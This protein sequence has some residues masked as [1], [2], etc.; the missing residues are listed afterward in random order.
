MPDIRARILQISDLHFGA[1]VDVKVETQV[2]NIVAEVQPDILIAS[3]DL[4]DSPKRKLREEAAKFL[5]SLLKTIT[6]P[7]ELIVIPGNH[8]YK[9]LFGSVEVGTKARRRFDAQFLNQALWTNGLFYRERPDLGVLIAGFN[10]NPPRF[11]WNA[12]GKVDGLA[13]QELENRFPDAAAFG[14][15]SPL[16]RIA[17]V[18]HH[19][20]PIVFVSTEREARLEERHMVFYNA[21]TF[22][23]TLNRKGFHLVLHG[24]KHFASFQRVGHEFADRGRRELA[25]AGAGSALHPHPDDPNGNHLQVVHLYDDGTAELDSWFYSAEVRR[26][27]G[28]SQHYPI[29][30]LAEVAHRRRRSF[31]LQRKLSAGELRREIRIT[32]DGFSEIDLQL[33][34]CR[35]PEGCERSG[36]LFSLEVFKPAY[37]RRVELAHIDSAPPLARLDPT[38][39]NLRAYRGNIDFQRTYTAQDPGFNLACRYRLMNGHALSKFDFQRKY[40]DQTYE[41]VTLPCFEVAG[42][43][44][45]IVYFPQNY[46]LQALGL[47]AAVLYKPG[48]MK[49]LDD[50]KFDELKLHAGETERVRERLFREA[51]RIVLQCS[52]PVPGFVYQVRWTFPDVNATPAA[53]WDAVNYWSDKKRALLEIAAG[54]ARQEFSAAGVYNRLRQILRELESGIRRNLNAGP[55]EM[56]LTLLAFDEREKALRVVASNLGKIEDLSRISLGTGE[57]CAGFAFEK[58]RPLFY[59]PTLAD[60]EDLYISP[61]E[62][63]M[64]EGQATLADYKCLASMPW[65]HPSGLIV[66]VLCVGSRTIPPPNHPVFGPEPAKVQ[67]LWDLLLPSANAILEV[68]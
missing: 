58:D 60:S 55:E 44:T 33:R 32:E 51:S 31:A 57:G 46:A 3:G 47:D 6:K 4:V 28:V 12:A 67:R 21:G 62:Q 43:L 53:G 66:G 65:R 24:H 61:A 36:Y 14:E 25:V 19:A 40:R 5:D 17:V 50:Y 45:L 38:L 7:C 42:T 39:R 10:S 68:V 13:L 37:L 29:V 1:G 35:I 49:D 20:L 34:H 8:D 9:G 27:P 18:H 26:K 2:R 15:A 11:E 22:L 30:D 52:D 54:A 56:D 48:P 59:A 63:K 16:F 23:W 41:Y 64:D